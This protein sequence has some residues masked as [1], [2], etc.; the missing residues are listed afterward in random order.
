[1]TDFADTY[2]FAE[3]VLVCGGAFAL[4][5][6]ISAGAGF[7]LEAVLGSSRR[8]WDLPRQEGQLRWEFRATLRFIV[9][10]GFSFAGLI[11][12][13]PVA[14]GDQDTMGRAILTF[15]ACWSVFE[16]YYWGMHRL[17]HYPQFFR[18]HRYHHDSK[19]TSP[20]TGYS[21]SATES[22]GWLLGLVGIPFLL[23]LVTPIS[24]SGLIAYH[25]LYQVPGN[26][27]GHSN[28]DPFPKTSGTRIGSWIN[29]PIVYHSLHHAR[30]SNH[31]S[32]GSSFMDRLLGTEWADWPEL[33]A[34]VIAGKPLQKLSERGSPTPTT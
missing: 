31:Y 19:V 2:S 13:V 8:I 3:W 4:I 33:H 34:R 18:F 21:M 27:V 28:V 29:H 15:F 32:F 26:V 1:M 12:V 10:A 11:W 16:I 20:L 9:M 25:V 22:A 6:A 17:M 30:L 14:T 24:I 23:G 7:A 5:I